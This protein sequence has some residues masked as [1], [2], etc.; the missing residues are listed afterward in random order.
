MN[1]LSRKVVLV[2]LAIGATIG[3]VKIMGSF[4]EEPLKVN[5]K[6]V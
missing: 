6:P 1:D 5:V 4:Q 2:L 3:I